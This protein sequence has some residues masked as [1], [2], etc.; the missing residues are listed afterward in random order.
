M[1]MTSSTV[2]VPVLLLQLLV[3]VLVARNFSAPGFDERVERIE[4]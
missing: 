1:I 3:V 2:S 4:P